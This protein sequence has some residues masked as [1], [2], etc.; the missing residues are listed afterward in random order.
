MQSSIF[1]NTV[2][3]SQERYVLQTPQMLRVDLSDGEDVV[4]YFD[5]DMKVHAPFDAQTLAQCVQRRSPAKD[6]PVE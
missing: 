2:T 6:R 3:Q 1:N 4:V 5:N